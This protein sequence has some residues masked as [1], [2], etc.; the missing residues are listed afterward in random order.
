MSSKP[1]AHE[2][3]I[4]SIKASVWRNQI[5]N[6]PYYNVT[7]TRLYKDGNL[8]RQSSHFGRD[9]LL[10]LAKCVDLAHTWIVTN[11]ESHGD[12]ASN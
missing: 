5:R 1:P 10:T 12:A 11:A 6:G 2:I 3:R 7:V 8:W 4:G 9:D